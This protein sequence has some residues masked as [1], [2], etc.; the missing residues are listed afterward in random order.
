MKNLLVYYDD[1]EQFTTKLEEIPI[2]SKL[3]P[4]DIL[5]KVAVAGSNPEDWKHPLPAY[6]D[7]KL[8]QGD[9]CAG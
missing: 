3:K 1:Q 7:N 2:P 9:D 4:H 8:N 6:F 5:I